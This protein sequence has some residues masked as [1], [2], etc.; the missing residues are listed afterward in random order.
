MTREIKLKNSDKVVLV[1]D[2]DYEE[3]VKHTWRLDRQGY[4]HRS[5]SRY[6]RDTK[7][8]ISRSI[9]LHRQIMGFPDSGIDHRDRNPLNNTRENL[10]IATGSQ[11]NA[12]KIKQSNNPHQYKGVHR[13]PRSPKWQASIRYNK[14]SIYLGMHECPKEAAKAYNKKAVELFGEFACLNEVD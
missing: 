4:P 1:D 9:G 14:K 2:E 12:N 8:K 6:C 5:T 10:R 13:H 3:L 7:K 11:N